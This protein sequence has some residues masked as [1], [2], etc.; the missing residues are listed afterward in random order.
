MGISMGGMG[1]L[2][3]GFTKPQLFGTIAVHSSAVLPDDPAKLA[4]RMKDMATQM[5]LADPEKWKLVNPLNLAEDAD[6]KKLDGLRLYFD[7]GTNDQH[8][9][10]PPNEQLHEVLEKRKIPHTFEL[11]QG[12]G[13]AWGSGFKAESLTKSLTFV[14]E[15]FKAAAG[16]G[17]KGDKADAKADKGKPAEPAKGEPGKG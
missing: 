16:K 3:I 12:G 14:G 11:V 2:R 15:G 4:G 7:A 9:F 1:A 6:P 13:H 17:A 10:G 5:G 8:E